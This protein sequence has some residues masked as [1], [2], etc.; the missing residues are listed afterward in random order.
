LQA[1]DRVIFGEFS[2]TDETNKQAE[3]RAS[4]RGSTKSVVRCDYIV[5]PGTLDEPVLTS[6]FRKAANV[7]RVIG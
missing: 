3:K 7:K 2:W 6:V 4:R 1:A 5:A